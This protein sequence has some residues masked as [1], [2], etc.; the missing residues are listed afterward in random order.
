M[1]PIGHVANFLEDKIYTLLLGYCLQGL[2]RE[3]FQ[4]CT[5]QCHRRMLEFMC[6]PNLV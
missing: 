3:T 2:R 1:A 6:I 4:I 5:S